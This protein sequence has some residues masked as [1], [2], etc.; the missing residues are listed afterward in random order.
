MLLAL[1]WQ[2]SKLR[3]FKSK[4][5]KIS[6][7]ELQKSFIPQ[8][9]A[10]NMYNKDSAIKMRIF[11]KKDFFQFFLSIF[12]TYSRTPK[13]FDVQSFKNFEKEV[14]KIAFLGKVK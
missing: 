6:N 13:N 3:L 9:K 1:E 4:S 5:I 14:S 12:F 8:K 10:N 7:F 2:W 11:A